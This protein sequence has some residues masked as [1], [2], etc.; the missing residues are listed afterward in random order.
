MP[1]LFHRRIRAILPFL[2]FAAVAAGMAAPDFTGTW[3]MDQAKTDF[4]PIP[5]PAS[6]V[7][8]IEQHDPV[9][10]VTTT[11]AREQGRVTAEFRYTT[12]GKENVNNLRGNAI[13]S[14]AH[15]EGDHLIFDSIWPSAGGDVRV[16]EDWLLSG[17]GKSL[18]VKRHLSAA[19]GEADQTIVFQRE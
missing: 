8:T 16:K 10:K 1:R 5:A 19:V 17:D 12:D 15:W 4:G 18:T 6:R 13:K 14:K 3:K 11:E 9:L 2:F 7:D